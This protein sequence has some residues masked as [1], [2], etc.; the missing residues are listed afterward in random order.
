M[1]QEYVQFSVNDGIKKVN[2]GIK[3]VKGGINQR[4]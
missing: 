3:K 1:C 2:D 4:G